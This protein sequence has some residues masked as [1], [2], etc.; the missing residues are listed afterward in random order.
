VLPGTLKS[1]A[2]WALKGRTWGARA[3]VRPHENTHMCLAVGLLSA[4]WDA[5]IGRFL[6]AQRAHLGRSSARAPPFFEA[7]LGRSR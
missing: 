5:Q 7:L 6:G 4:P 3:P 2:F 1:D